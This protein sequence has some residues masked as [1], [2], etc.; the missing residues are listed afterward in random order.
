MYQKQALNVTVSGGLFLLMST[1]MALFAST[2]I[3]AVLM[4]GAEA[5]EIFLAILVQVFV[6]DDMPSSETL[7]G[8]SLVVFC[9]I[10]LVLED[11][12]LSACQRAEKEEKC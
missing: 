7:I 6:M 1:L 12:L 4:T 10:M 5:S 11:C 2:F 9:I 3:P 8:A